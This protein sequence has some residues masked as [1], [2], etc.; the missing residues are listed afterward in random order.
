MVT[1]FE[2]G[3]AEAT[4]LKY[5]GRLIARLA[6]GGERE[7]LYRDLEPGELRNELMRAAGV[8]EEPQPPS[9]A[10][11][12][13]APLRF[14]GSGSE[15]FRI[16]AVH[17]LLTLLTLGVYSA[18][19][20]VRK[21]RWFAQHTVLL[22][23]RFDYHGDPRRVLLGRAIAL[24][25]VVAWSWAFDIGFWTGVGVLGVLCVLGPALFASA[26][27]F[28]LSNT[29]WRGLR[30]GHEVPASRV[31]AVCLP[32]LLIWTSGTVASAYMDHVGGL[33]TALGD[34]WPMWLSLGATLAL[35]WAHARLKQLQHGH[36]RF[37]A[38]QFRFTP[39]TAGF[40]GLY[41]LG[42]AFFIG[43]GVLL[44]LGAL[45]MRELVGT[46]RL[47]V[48]E[49]VIWTAAAV[50]LTWLLAWPYLAARAQQVVWRATRLGEHL[51]FESTIQGRRFQGIIVRQTLLTLVTLG[52]YWPFA[53][54][55]ITRYRVECLRV[56]SEGVPIRDAVAP[57]RSPGER[58]ATGD[59]AA[60]AFGLDLGW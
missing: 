56:V 37:G 51:S 2:P 23:D 47:G 36:A 49:M 22:G 60:E 31:Y 50:L 35:P 6:A 4:G 18:W 43:V 55:A 17:L 15:Y 42:V 41:A 45:T 25:L 7:S 14:D 3:P 54:V 46:A 34:M 52:I 57:A 28:R 40:Y 29:S 44:V 20:K 11:E 8:V 10:P 33:P 59:A 39:S 38:W 58:R 32:L 27:R 21:A 24:V 19:A 9:L 16:W 53:A 1:P 12:Y 5:P 30:F 13:S 48:L 26:Q